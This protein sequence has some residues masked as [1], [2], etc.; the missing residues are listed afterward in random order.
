MGCRM[1]GVECTAAGGG[2]RVEGEE[3]RVKVV[4]CRLCGA[5]CIVQVVVC[6]V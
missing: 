4:S 2:W 5:G 6:S 1:Q 3:W